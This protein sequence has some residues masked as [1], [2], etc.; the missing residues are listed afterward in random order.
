MQIGLR[1]EAKAIADKVKGIGCSLPLG[2]YIIKARALI[3]WV[4]LGGNILSK[5]PCVSID[6]PFPKV[7]GYIV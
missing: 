1:M 3:R 7:L 2:V 6:A 4:L 5:N